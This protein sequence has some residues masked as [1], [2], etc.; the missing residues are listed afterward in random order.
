MN[1]LKT[2]KEFQESNEWSVHAAEQLVF[3]Q[4]VQINGVYEQVLWDKLCQLV[5]IV[6]IIP[7]KALEKIDT[8]GG[9]VWSG[10]V[11]LDEYRCYRFKG[12]A[13]YLNSPR[14]D[15]LDYLA[16]TRAALHKVDFS[17]L[18]PDI[19]IS[20][21]L[22]DPFEYEPSRESANTGPEQEG[23]SAGANPRVP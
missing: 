18:R 8:P 9:P 10:K 2:L 4:I 17:R 13:I 23:Q 3:P 11:A 16:E 7:I 15:L 14:C 12:T 22:T 1:Q 6:W 20:Y 19:T 5:I 21:K